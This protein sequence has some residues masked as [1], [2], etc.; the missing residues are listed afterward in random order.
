MRKDL[1]EVVPV[2]KEQIKK[3]NEEKKKYLRGYKK[4]CRKIEL[5]NAKIEELQRL[6]RNPSVRNDGMPRG[7]NQS[8][9]S[10]YAAQLD[11]LEDELYNEG[12]AE[13]KIYKDITCRIDELEDEDEREVLYY[14]YIKDKEWWEIAKTMGFSESWIYELH[15][16]ALKNLKIS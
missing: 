9:L 3:E 8:D 14:R 5:I 4:H 7:S 2:D 1:R 15:G 10:D 12:V 16:R 6:K 11:T 13:V